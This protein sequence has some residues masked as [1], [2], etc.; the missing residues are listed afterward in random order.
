[1][2]TKA[3]SKAKRPKKQPVLYKGPSSAPVYATSQVRPK[4]NHPQEPPAKRA[5]TTRVVYVEQKKKKL[6]VVSGHKQL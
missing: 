1:M 3:S 5:K 6:Q 2:P 4:E